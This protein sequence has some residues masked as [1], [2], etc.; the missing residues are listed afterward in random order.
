[1]A[2]LKKLSNKEAEQRRNAMLLAALVDRLN[3]KTHV[4]TKELPVYLLVVARGGPK[5]KET[6]AGTQGGF[7]VRAGELSGHGILMESLAYSVGGATGRIVIEKTG[8]TGRY[9]IE[10][11]WAADRAEGATNDTGPDIFTALQEQLGLKLESGKAPIES[12]II[13]HIEKPSEN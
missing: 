11:K 12:V 10:L 4:A 9:D 13:E 6:P 3:L 8:L 2:A 1:V 7:T 5:L